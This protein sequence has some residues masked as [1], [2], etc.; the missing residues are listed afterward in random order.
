MIDIMVE[1]GF[2]GINFGNTSTDYKGL[3][4]QIDDEDLEKYDY[5]TNEFGGGLSGRIL[6]LRSLTLSQMNLYKITL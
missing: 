5:F 4:G 6:K 1:L 2:S 3:R